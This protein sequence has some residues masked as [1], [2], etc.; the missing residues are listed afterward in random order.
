MTEKKALLIS[1]ERSTFQGALWGAHDRELPLNVAY[2]AAFLESEG[3]GADALDLQLQLD[4]DAALRGMN[5]SRYFIFGLS[6]NLSGAYAAYRTADLLKKLAPGIPIALFGAASVLKSIALNECESIDYVILNEEETTFRELA[7]RTASGGDVSDVRGL[8]HRRGNNPI[9]NPQ[10][11]YLRDL[12]SLPFPARHKFDVKQYFPSPGKYKLMPQF[13]M[14]SSRGCNGDCLFCPRL[15]GK[16]MRFRSAGNI[17]DEIDLLICDYRAREIFF[18]DDTFTA[19]RERVMA[20][21]ELAAGRKIAFRVASRV[22]MVDEEMLA[23][24]KRAGLYSIGYGIESGA[25]EILKINR[26]GVNTQQIRKAVETTKKLGLEARGFFMLNMAGDTRE[27]TEKTIA[28]MASLPLDL[29]NVQITYPWPNSAMRQYVADKGLAINNEKWNDW[30]RCRGDEAVFTQND[31]DADYLVET[32]K[33]VVRNFYMNPRF[34]LKWL[35][36]IRT[37]HDF[38]Y[39]FLQF[40]A[41]AKSVVGGRAGAKTD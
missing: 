13:T 22:D 3:F 27:T 12:D 37:Y 14:L 6:A 25:D 11:E 9:E 30:T 32:Y 26:K 15:T 40:L 28:F 19:D 34:I 8:A 4:A 23:A 24:L 29:V 38:K 5:F 33:R 17:M 21:A 31:L 2:L 20:F 16:G 41:L 18:V 39:A 7:A 36:R 1:A 10:R 35:S